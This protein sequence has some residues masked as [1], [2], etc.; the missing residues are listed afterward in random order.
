MF[1]IYKIYEN[2]KIENLND[3]EF[4]FPKIKKNH[5]VSMYQNVLMF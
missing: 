1:I 4:I 5:L 3:D 2:N